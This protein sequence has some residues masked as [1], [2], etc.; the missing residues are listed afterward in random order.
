MPEHKPQ[1]TSWR[2]SLSRAWNRLGRRSK[3]RRALVAAV[4][5]LAVLAVFVAL[6]SY[7][8]SQPDF[9]GHYPDMKMQH[10]TWTT[11]VHA[12]VPCEGCHVS[13]NLFAQGV[14]YVRMAGEFYLSVIPGRDPQLLS[15][16]TNDSCLQCHS[17][18]RTVSP[19]GDLNIPHRAHVEVVKVQCVVCHKYL[20]HEKSPEGKNKPAMATCLTCHNGVTAKNNCSA[21][22]RNKALPP[23]HQ[24]ADWIFIHPTKVGVI[25]CAQCHKWTATNYC[26]KCHSTRPRSHTA[27]WRSDHGARALA[28]RDCEVCHQRSFCIHCHGQFPTANLGTDPLD[29]PIP[30]TPPTTTP[31]ATATTSAQ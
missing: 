7:I 15:K 1:K 13:P 10:D 30:A 17:D 9:L 5:V 28:H 23:T 26:A 6:P 19:S 25:D 3:F 14:W 16:P 2:D 31:S 24:A 22:H 11:S 20:V 27:T 29:H 12:N 18:L 4:G 21:C 8:A